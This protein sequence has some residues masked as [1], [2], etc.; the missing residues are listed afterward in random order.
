MNASPATRPKTRWAII[1]FALLAILIAG[2]IVTYG[3]YAVASVPML[4]C[5]VFL[6]GAAR[7]RKPL[8]QNANSPGGDERGCAHTRVHFRIVGE[9]LGGIGCE[10]PKFV[11]QA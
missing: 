7:H 6:V 9:I 11:P 1:V 2:L 8:E 3:A 4:L 10:A 5:P